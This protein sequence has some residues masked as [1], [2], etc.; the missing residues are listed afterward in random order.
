MSKSKTKK[1]AAKARAAK[2]AVQPHEGS[3]EVVKSQPREEL[4]VFAFRLTTDERDAIHQAAG[5]A[6]ASKFAR[7]LLVAAARRDVEAIRAILKSAQSQ[8]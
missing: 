6:K 3:P 5:P 2:K 1:S 8:A 7:E 4:C